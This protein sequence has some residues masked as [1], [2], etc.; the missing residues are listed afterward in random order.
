MNFK[1]R[2]FMFFLF[3]TF[4][5]MTEAKS[6]TKSDLPAISHKWPVCEWFNLGWVLK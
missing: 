4:C 6:P 1:N 5:S 3:Y 2:C